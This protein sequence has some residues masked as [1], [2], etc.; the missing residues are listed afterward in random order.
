MHQMQNGKTIL[1]TWCDKRAERVVEETQLTNGA[2]R[3]TL[4]QY[5]CEDHMDRPSTSSERIEAMSYDELG[6]AAWLYIRKRLPSGIIPSYLGLNEA[7]QMLHTE[8]A[9]LFPPPARC[10]QKGK[11]KPKKQKTPRID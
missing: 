3:V 7:M 9:D 6:T 11:A 1:C 4:T 8:L 5:A 10:E 2:V